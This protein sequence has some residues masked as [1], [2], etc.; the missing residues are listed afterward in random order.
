MNECDECGESVGYYGY[1]KT[2]HI[3]NDGNGLIC[4]ECCVATDYLI[5][6]YAF[7]K[8]ALTGNK[9]MIGE[10]SKGVPHL[11]PAFERY[12]CM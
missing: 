4:Q 1:P 6:G 10:R 11:D 5:D 12:H 8:N 9:I 3:R 7:S 2:L